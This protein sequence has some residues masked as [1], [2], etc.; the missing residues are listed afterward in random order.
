MAL[1]GLVPKRLASKKIFDCLKQC[2]ALEAVS[3][4]VVGSSRRRCRHHSTLL[5][6]KRQGRWNSQSMLT[7]A[8]AAVAATQAFSTVGRRSTARRSSSSSRGIDDATDSFETSSASSLPTSTTASSSTLAASA[9]TL[10]LYRDCLR[11][12][13][14]IAP[15]GTGTA[16]N[17]HVALKRSVTT[18]FKRN[19]YETD[20]HAI[21]RFK[22][23]AVRALSN[24]LLMAS[25][26]SN[27]NNSNSKSSD[28][29][30]SQS[31]GATGS[32]STSVTDTA[33]SKDRRPSKSSSS[34]HTKLSAAMQSYHDRSVAEAK[35]KQ[36]QQEDTG[37]DANPISRE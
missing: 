23:D 13:H 37:T 32:A 14:H 17:K 6:E 18:Q 12:V 27:A 26:N 5:Y 2:T 1:Y 10:K 21:E 33:N 34:Q 19:M 15:G 22:A 20:E 25:I 4:Q 35:L 24:Y 29:K 11:L 8:S 30:T 9:T 31:R 7:R 36:R 16:S 3:I 28:A